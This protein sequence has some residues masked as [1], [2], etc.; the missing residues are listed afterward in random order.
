MFRVGID[1]GGTNTDAVIMRGRDVVAAMKTST[2]VDLMSGVLAALEGVVRKAGV[3]KDS[4]A[5]VMLGT[6]HFTNAIAERRNLVPVGVLRLALPATEAVPPLTGWPSDITAAVQA[7]CRMVHGGY[8]FDGREIAE[9]DPEE[10]RAFA[11]ECAA[12]GVKHFAISGAFSSIN[13]LQELMAAAL[14]R[15][16]VPN[17]GITLSSEIGRLGL[18]D[19]ENATV[20]N[21]ALG[22]LGAT[23][24]DAFTKALRE[25]GVRAPF[26]LTQNDGTLMTASRAAQFPILTV[27]S[28]PTNSMRG[29][30]FLSDC[31]DAIV[32][33]VG[34]TTSDI[35]VLQNGFPRQAGT[36]IEVGGVR[37]N[38]RMPDV[39][40]LALGGGTR[41]RDDFRTIGPDSVGF[42]IASEALVFG[43]DT[44]TATDIAVACGAAQVGDASKVQSLSRESCVGC[45]ARMREMLANAVE[46]MRTSSDI[47]PV[48]AVGGGSHLIGARIGDLPVIVPAHFAV[49]NAVGAAMA[50]VS[51]EVDRVVDLTGTTR[52]AALLEVCSEAK[53]KAVAAGADPDSVNVIDTEDVPLAYL[54]GNSTR[55]R[56]RVVGDLL[57][58]R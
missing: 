46:R 31:K 39:L 43:G 6:T 27:A 54:P 12:G 47:V 37:T 40:S 28:G 34:G 51:G 1:V 8:E 41:V 24:A 29:A 56:V 2:T 5:A 30:A 32:V 14:V 13:D 9:L 18:L 19:R 3:P 55:L 10:I 53:G 49:A 11:L 25:A 52:E 48:L 20:L 35:G 44:L 15:R 33:D 58:A 45:L 16:V 4:L 57:L 36:S 22:G 26:Y 42:R 7:T 50:Q 38:F 23:L 17:A 21:A